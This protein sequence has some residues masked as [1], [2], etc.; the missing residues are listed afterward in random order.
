MVDQ[1]ALSH[2]SCPEGILSQI[3]DGASLSKDILLL[4][5]KAYDENSSYCS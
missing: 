5:L 2:A 3:I 4:C 1:A